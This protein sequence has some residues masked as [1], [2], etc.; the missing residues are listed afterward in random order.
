MFEEIEGVLRWKCDHCPA[1]A[2][3]DGADFREAWYRLKDRG[4]AAMSLG[5]GGWTHWCPKCRR[6]VG[7]KSVLDRPG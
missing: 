5:D 1:S 6:G 7:G 3:F 2:E 4:W